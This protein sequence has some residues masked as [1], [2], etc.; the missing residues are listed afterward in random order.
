MPARY[1]APF[2]CWLASTSRLF[3]LMMTL[4]LGHD[5]FICNIAYSLIIKEERKR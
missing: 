4:K 3:T 5:N 1:Q 2:F